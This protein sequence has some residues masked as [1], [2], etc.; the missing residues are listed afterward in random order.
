MVL[1]DLLGLAVANQVT[2]GVAHMGDDGLVVAEG[3]GYQRGGHLFASV[4]GVQG[5]IVNGGV[6]VLDQAGKQADQHGSRLRLGKLFRHDGNGR[7]R[8]DFAQIHA[9][10]A[11]GNCEQVAVRAGL[12]ARSRD[13][14]SHRVFI[15][16]ADLAKIASLSLLKQPPYM[17]YWIFGAVGLGMASPYLVIGAFPKLIRFLPKPG[18]WMETVQQLMGF[19]LLATVVYLFTTLI[20]PYFVPTLALLVGL[21]FAC[22]WIGRTPLTAT[23]G[24]P[25]GLGRRSGRGGAGGTVRLHGALPG[26]EDSLAAVLARGARARPG[27]GQD[28]D[29]RLFGQLVPQLQD[30][31]EVRRR[32]R[33]RAELIK[34]NGV[35]PCWP[36]GPTGRR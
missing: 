1:G 7:G 20:A 22:W 18:A 8:G 29:G 15:I 19:L 36:T 14:R 13:E 9:A 28:G 10:H 11:V 6:G 24:R 32:D 30:E 31:L 3:A 17:A 21:W 33:S 16:L 4:F 5:A 27:R 25:C 23:A 12:V 2:A 34:A 26:V 35:V